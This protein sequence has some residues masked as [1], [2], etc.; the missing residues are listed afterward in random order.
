LAI[1]G[2][3][4]AAMVIEQQMIGWNEKSHFAQV[5]AF[6]HGTPIIDAYH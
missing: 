3:A 1:L 6:D 5:R 4:L 2:C